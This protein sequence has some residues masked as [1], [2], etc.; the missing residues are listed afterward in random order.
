[1]KKWFLTAALSV[2][3]GIILYATLV[4]RVYQKEIIINAPLL[5][6]N[7]QISVIG[8]FAKWHPAIAGT[9]SATISISGNDK[10]STGKTSLQIVTLTERSCLLRISE[11]EQ[12]KDV[13]YSIT[14]DTVRRNR[15][16]ILYKT[17]FWK[18]ITGSDPLVQ[19]AEKSLTSLKEYT[20]DTRR[21]YGY[22]ISL[23]Q[24]TDTAFLFTS[25][26]VANKEKKASIKKLYQLLTA[27]AAAKDAGFTGTTIFYIMAAGKDS[28]RLYQ[29]IGVS[30][31]TMQL[32]LYGPVSLKRMP[33]KK[34]LVVAD[35]EGKFGDIPKVFT[36][37]EQFGIDDKMVSMAIPFIKFAEGEDDFDD[38]KVI[39]V[40]AFFPVR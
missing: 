3:A 2:L 29:S 25:E 14:E 34:N 5:R 13:L 21:V 24:V 26:V 6:L 16:T 32:P 40:R 39:K 28:V 33:Y 19:A 15:V 20:E 10:V 17:T 23:T 18:K 31:N 8:N 4:P 1:M 22:N 11:K 37:L 36:A 27:Y 35:Y 30:K 38:E 12:S 7:K 9:D